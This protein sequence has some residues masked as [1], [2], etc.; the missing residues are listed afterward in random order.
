V[1]SMM[2]T[3]VQEAVAT[4]RSGERQGPDTKQQK[5]TEE[6]MSRDHD[7]CG[8]G[9][10]RHTPAN[11][12]I[13]ERG[14]QQRREAEAELFRSQLAVGSRLV[15]DRGFRYW[16]LWRRWRGM[17]PF[18]R[19]GEDAM[20]D[21]NELIRF[22][23]YFGVVCEYAYSTVHGWLH[24]I[25][26][27]HILHGLGDPLA[28][29]LRLRLVRKGLKRLEQRRRGPTR[30][31]AA[32]AELLHEVIENGGLNIM[33]WNDSVLITA[34]LFG[35]F[36]LRRSSEFLRKGVQPDNDK[37]VRV[38]DCVL[39]REGQILGMSDSRTTEADELIAT[40]RR[41][42][43]DQEGRGTV[44][45][46]FLSGDRRLCV[47]TWFKHLLK[48]NPTHFQD[49]LRFLFTLSDGRVLSRDAVSE[50]LKAATRRLGMKEADID[51]I[52]L[53]AGGA[54]TMYHAGFTVEEIQ[55]RGRWASDCWKVY[56]H[57]GRTKARN[58]AARMVAT[59]LTLL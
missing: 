16:W 38:G 24:G 12:R 7:R 40:Q 19:G 49:P 35:F 1:A 58:V 26:H 48:L 39:A 50:A 42:K 13:G 51:V 47:V 54:S 3:F 41:S 43:V 18:M 23:S 55:R 22:Y 52:S 20:I 9:K 14:E 46:T 33:T 30:K 44:T 32:T 28:G 59:K 56:V 5:R 57:E 29:K 34:I 8:G 17:A 31:L 36:K 45:N 11:I 53:R 21:E 6:M 4:E 25:Q 2:K 27:A 37:C 10:Q 15:Y